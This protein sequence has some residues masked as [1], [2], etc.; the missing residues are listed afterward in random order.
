[1]RCPR[2]RFYRFHIL[3]GYNLLEL[4]IKLIE[5]SYSS[6]LLGFYKCVFGHSPLLTK[7]F[8]ELIRRSPRSVPPRLINRRCV[9]SVLKP[10][11][12][13]ILHLASLSFCFLQIDNYNSLEHTTSRTTSLFFYHI[14]YS[15]LSILQWHI[16]FPRDIIF[17]PNLKSKMISDWCRQ[18]CLISWWVWCEYPHDTVLLICKQ[19]SDYSIFVHEWRA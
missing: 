14:W 1:M 19:S 13:N 3:R 15:N 6:G 11:M 5:A 7:Q 12:I 10:V 18:Y 4:K 2:S 9:F 8:S 16:D 17:S